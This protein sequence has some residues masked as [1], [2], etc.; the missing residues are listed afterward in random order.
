MEPPKT[1]EEVEVVAQKI[2]LTTSTICKELG[3]KII[4]PNIQLPTILEEAEQRFKY[5]S[6]EERGIILNKWKRLAIERIETASTLCE[7][8]RVFD[9]CHDESKEKRKAL[10]KCKKL[11]AKELKKA[12]TLHEIK[13]VLINFSFGSKEKKK[14]LKKL[15]KA[16]LKKIKETST[17]DELIEI[18]YE[19]TSCNR[20][21]QKLAIKKCLCLCSSA[22]EA[23]EL[24]YSARYRNRMEGRQI[25]TKWIELCSTIDNIEEV[26]NCILMFSDNELKEM[27]SLKQI[28]LCSNAKEAEKL[29]YHLPNK[30]KEKKAALLKWISLS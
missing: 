16:S 23:R 7:I 15:K 28:E 26:H 24:Y 27:S 1:M 9:L 3:L 5:S 18:I 2:G 12:S 22:N 4:S 8:N 13:Q 25:L 11:F 29:F 20:K 14:A 30:S 17:F 6:P 19:Y 10:K 21:G